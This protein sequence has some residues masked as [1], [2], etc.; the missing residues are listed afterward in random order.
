[1]TRI[2]VFLRNISY[3]NTQIKRPWITRSTCTKNL[4]SKLSYEKAARKFLVKL[5]T[6]RTKFFL[7][8]WLSW[9]LQRL[10]KNYNHFLRYSFRLFSSPVFLPLNQK[11]RRRNLFLK[12]IFL[13][14]DFLLIFHQYFALLAFPLRLTSPIGC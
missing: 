11:K 10:G 7:R 5:T 2:L 4:R 13:F 3:A 12:L 14:L 8:F 6:L 9:W 1:M